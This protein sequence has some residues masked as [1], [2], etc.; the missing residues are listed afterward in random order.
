MTELLRGQRN[1]AKSEVV[2]KAT[3]KPTLSLVSGNVV[4][5]GGQCVGR[6][7]TLLVTGHGEAAAKTSG[8][9]YQIVDLSQSKLYEGWK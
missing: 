9:D 2:Q 7:G 6:G 3:G 8:L 1:I 4:M 5:V